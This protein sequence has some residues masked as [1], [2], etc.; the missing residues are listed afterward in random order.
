MDNKTNFLAV[1]V[2]SLFLLLTIAG[3]LLFTAFNKKVV[4]IDT[5]PP[6]AQYKVSGNEGTTPAKIKLKPGRHEIELTKDGYEPLKASF[7]ISS[8][9]KKP[10]F[11]YSL[12][13]LPKVN[14]TN[15]SRNNN[16]GSVIDPTWWQ[17]ASEVKRK[18]PF[19]DKLP[20]KGYNFYI[21]I[22]TQ[23]DKFFV[24]ISSNNPAGSKS[25][26]LKWFTDNGIA[27]P[28]TLNIVWQ[29]GQ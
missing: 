28:G 6:G 2:L 3:F 5:A 13:E 4:T 23:D 27:N 17:K 8:F 16:F 21:S 15:E 20:Y 24:Y 14:P 19:Y 18:Y 7:S 11:S 26:A 9:D 10:S 25:D 12:K 1:A 22:P 29:Y